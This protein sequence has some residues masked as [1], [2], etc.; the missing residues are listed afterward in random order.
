[1]VHRFGM[2]A[3]KAYLELRILDGWLRVED[4]WLQF[5]ESSVFSDL[6]GSNPINPKP[7]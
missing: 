5:P 6:S 2:E 7:S 3:C 4:L 1:M